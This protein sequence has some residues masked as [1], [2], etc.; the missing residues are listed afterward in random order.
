MKKKVIIKVTRSSLKFVQGLTAI[1]YS[2]KRIFEPRRLYKHINNISYSNNKRCV[3]DLY[4]TNKEKKNILLINIHGGF[5]VGSSR[6]DNFMLAHYFLRKGIDVALVEY[7]L[8]NKTIET[9]DELQDVNDCISYI[10]NHLKE[11]NLQY[12]SIYLMGDSAGGHF[13][14]MNALALNCQT[15][16]L[17]NDYKVSG[18]ILSCPAY[19][20]QDYHS[21][22]ELSN[23]VKRW[24]LG[25]NYK[26]PQYLKT[27]SSK[28]YID[29]LKLPI[30]I[31]TS[32][33]DFLRHDSL[34]LIADLDKNNINYT[35][36]DINSN[37]PLAGHVHNVMHPWLKES[38]KVNKAIY[39][40]MIKNIKVEN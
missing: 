7:R 2:V 24:V 16:L 14:L 11:L 9:K 35:F 12:D 1:H 28:T 27:L 33:T 22:D 20:Y 8:N 25:K 36:I 19:N 6:K 13:A 17:K 37:N 3:F 40:F 32:K 34:D 5:Y 10:Y 31:S 4:Y 38:I 15:P 29:N 23:G 30:F 26:D 21:Y 39:D 18:V